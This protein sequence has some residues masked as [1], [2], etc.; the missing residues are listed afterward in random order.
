MSYFLL[1]VAMFIV[2]HQVST[3]SA[4]QYMISHTYTCSCRHLVTMTII[5]IFQG[6]PTL[7]EDDSKNCVVRIDWTTK[8]ACP[9][10]SRV[11]DWFVEDPVTHQQFNLSALPPLLYSTYTEADDSK[12]NY[13]VGLGGSAVVCPG[14][15]GA[16]LHIGACQYTL[17]SVETHTHSVHSLGSISS[18]TTLQYVGGEISVEYLHGDECHRVLRERKTVVSFACEQ[19]RN[20][21]LE[22]FPEEECEYSFV[23]HTDIVCKESNN[24][25]VP[26]MLPHFAN[27]DVFQARG[28]VEVKLNDTAMVLFTVCSTLDSRRPPKCP[29]GAAVCLLDSSL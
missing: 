15:N 26:C 29:K 10:D 28:M 6:E 12:Y 2:Q 8:Y 17:S 13:T 22:V 23:V 18:N 9:R 16:L 21:F 1:V 7:V 14:K 3:I 24:I 27:L 25:G 4:P 11:A 19:S 20:A 5:I